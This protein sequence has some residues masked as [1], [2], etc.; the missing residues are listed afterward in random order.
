MLKP[1]IFPLPLN[2]SHQAG[3]F[4][5]LSVGSIK[6]KFQYA[7]RVIQQFNSVQFSRSVMSNSLWPHGWQHIRLPCPLPSPG[8]CSNSCPSSRW[9]HPAI[10]SSVVLF[11]SCLQ[12]FPASGSFPVSQFLASGG[13]SVRVSAL[14][15]I[16]PMN[17]QGWFPDWFDLLAVQGTLKNL[18]QHHSSKASV[19][20]CSTFFMV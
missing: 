7:D 14:A 6:N 17:I 20:W 8:A 15:S 1:K 2:V 19:I 11:S 13:Q 3:V 18:L 5:F 16:H 10:S 4:S 9:C 12:S